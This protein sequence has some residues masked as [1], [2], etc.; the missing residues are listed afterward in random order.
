MLPTLPGWSYEDLLSLSALMVYWFSS[1]L[2]SLEDFLIEI[3]R[4][5]YHLKSP[6]SA[7][8]PNPYLPEQGSWLSLHSAGC[9]HDLLK[10]FSFPFFSTPTLNLYTSAHHSRCMNSSCISESSITASCVW[11]RKD[12][13]SASQ[14]K[15][16]THR[17]LILR[18]HSQMCAKAEGL[19]IRSVS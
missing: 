16:M 1:A 11:G 13:L 10:L 12:S 8:G 6:S 9:S 2:S 3:T 5:W 19:Y 14:V 18:I 7:K 15:N 17:Q 4:S